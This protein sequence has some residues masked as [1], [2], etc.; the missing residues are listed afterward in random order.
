MLE[1]G[2]EG[3]MHCREAVKVAKETVTLLTFELMDARLS[4]FER[5]QYPD[6]ATGMRWVLFF[7]NQ[8]S[9]IPGVVIEQ[10]KGAQ[11]KGAQRDGT[12]VC[13]EYGGE[14]LTACLDR[15]PR[16]ATHSRRV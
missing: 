11:G 13:H 14:G 15:T 7:V 9:H 2:N 8:Y 1:R 4:S 12:T 6:S 3:L 5:N 10:A 16:R